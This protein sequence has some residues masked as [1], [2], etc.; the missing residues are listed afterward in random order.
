MTVKCWLYAC[1]RL[2]VLVYKCESLIIFFSYFYLN[3][4]EV[5]IKYA[6]ANFLTCQ[7]DELGKL[8]ISRLLRY[9]LDSRF[10]NAIAAWSL[11]SMHWRRRPFGLLASHWVLQS[12][13][14]VHAASLKH[15]CQHQ[16]CNQG[17]GPI[18]RTASASFQPCPEQFLALCPREFH[19]DRVSSDALDTSYIAH[20]H[21]T[22]LL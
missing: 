15:N 12:C 1:A 8:V 5:D 7:N 21:Y 14:H 4:K 17:N 18:L 6:T 13:M 19:N 2:F 11:C 3:F 20:S 16:S 9:N 22:H 10:A